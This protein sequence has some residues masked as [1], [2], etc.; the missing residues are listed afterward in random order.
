MEGTLSPLFVCTGIMDLASEIRS[1]VEKSINNPEHFLV[2]VIVSTRKGPKKIMVFLDGD[3][4]IGIDDCASLSRQ[5]N[6]FLETKLP[7]E[8]PYSLDV[9]S[10]GV[11]H[12]LKLNRQYPK[13]I[14]RKLKVSYT[15]KQTEGRLVEVTPEKVVLETEMGT[16][17]KKVTGREEIP[18]AEIEKA[19]VTVSFK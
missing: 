19:F 15:G 18:F 12:P 16:G 13:H 11:D 9:S 3:H 7:E 8:E 6:Q 10:P 14:G 17:K 2:D 1:W 5:L 4:G